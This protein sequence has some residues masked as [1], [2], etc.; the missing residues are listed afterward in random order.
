MAEAHAVSL[1][2]LAALAL[3]LA[4]AVAV[5]W[6]LGKAPEDDTAKAPP[7]AP[8]LARS[9]RE[10]AAIEVRRGDGTIMTDR[11]SLCEDTGIHHTMPYRCACGC[12]PM[13][14]ALGL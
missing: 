9:P 10:V 7:E 14:E 12:H 2:A 8:L 5:V 4:A 3:A 13:R 6:W 1:R 11:C